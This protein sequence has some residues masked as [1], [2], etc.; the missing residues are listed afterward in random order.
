VG[1][2]HLSRA[3]AEPAAIVGP[4]ADLLE[5][6]GGSPMSRADLCRCPRQGIPHPVQTRLLGGW[7]RDLLGPVVLWIVM[8]GCLLPPELLGDL[9]LQVCHGHD[10]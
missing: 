7:R 3:V 2:C 1:P 5:V 6:D 10:S 9:K 8:P 4:L